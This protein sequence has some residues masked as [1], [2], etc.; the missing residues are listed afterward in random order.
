MKTIHLLIIYIV[1]LSTTPIMSG[2]NLYSNFKDE[3]YP[4]DQDII[5]IPFLTITVTC[6]ASLLLLFIQRHYRTKKLIGA[7]QAIMAA[8]VILAST[9]I[10]TALLIGHIIYWSSPHHLLTAGAFM[11]TFCFYVCYQLH[12]Y[13][14]RFRGRLWLL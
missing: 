1:S 8:L 10:T 5:A 7:F 13:G 14:R 3:I 11:A 2:I 4:I 6:T 12:F 9:A